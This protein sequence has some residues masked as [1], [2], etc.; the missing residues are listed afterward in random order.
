M[1]IGI[2]R[3]LDKRGGL[4]QLQYNLDSSRWEGILGKR[5]CA[6]NIPVDVDAMRGGGKIGGGDGGE[7]W[8]L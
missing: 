6:R 3:P 5:R 2:V 1:A 8:W 4:R 7:G